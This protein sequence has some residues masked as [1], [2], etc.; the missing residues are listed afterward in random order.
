MSSPPSGEIKDDWRSNELDADPEASRL[1]GDLK[2]IQRRGIGMFG[3]LVDCAIR[4]Y[5]VRGR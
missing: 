5:L 2:A 1:V 4:T 3:C